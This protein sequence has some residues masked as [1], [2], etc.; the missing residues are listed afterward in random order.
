MRY[1]EE[2]KKR[3]STKQLMF[4]TI[5][6]MPNI[7]EWFI[8]LEGEGHSIGE[9]SLYI[10]LNGCYSAKCSWCDSKYSWFTDE[11][12]SNLEEIGKSI[13]KEIK[14]KEII[15][16]NSLDDSPVI[17]SFSKSAPPLSTGLTNP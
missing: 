13:L 9:P 5:D 17:K 1:S 10:R 3:V 16:N 2:D 12:K 14:N 8:S 6:R 7:S 15:D 4:G 11:G